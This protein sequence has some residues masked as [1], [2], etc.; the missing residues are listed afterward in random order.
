[1]S[2]F[3]LL[4]LTWVLISYLWPNW[5]PVCLCLGM[6]NLTPRISWSGTM[7]PVWCWEGSLQGSSSGVHT[8]CVHLPYFVTIMSLCL[9]CSVLVN[10]VIHYAFHILSYL[11]KD[12][13]IWP[14]HTYVWCLD[15][16]YTQIDRE[17]RMMSTLHSVGFP[18]PQPIHYC[19][20]PDIIGTE[21]YLMEYVQV[22]SFVFQC[23]IYLF[24]DL[25]CC[26][27]L[28]RAVCSEM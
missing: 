5:P 25:I 12:G 3:N 13:S 19:N 24:S 14:A 4:L 16:F 8:G 7:G 2:I 6:V 15:P 11:R 23:L 9:V 26:T 1:M 20:S 28:T 18:V 27:L 22:R 17:Y 21:F 10:Y